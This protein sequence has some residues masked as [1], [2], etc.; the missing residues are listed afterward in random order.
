MSQEED[1]LIEPSAQGCDLGT[2][3]ANEELHLWP[4]E[5][6]AELADIPSPLKLPDTIDCS[7]L[8]PEAV[9]KHYWGYDEFRP[10][11]RDIVL[12]VLE[13]HDTLGLLPTGGG[14]SITFQVPGLMLPG[15]TLVVTPLISLM[16]D[17]V[18]HLRHRGIKAAAIHS[19]MHSNRISQTLDNCIYGRYKFLYVSPERLASSAF[20]AKLEALDISLL[21][22]DEC[23]CICQ[24][25]YDFR[26]SYLNILELRSLVPDVPIIALTATATPDVV[27]EVRRV[28]GFGCD[29]RTYQKSFFRPNLSYSIRYSPDKEQ[30]MLHILSRVAGSAIVYC[31]SRDLCRSIAK[32]LNE[33]GHSAT[34]FHAGLT[35]TERALR[36]SRW[37]RGEI[38]VMVATNA[39]GMGIDKPDVRLVLHLAMPTS[40]EEYFQEAG[41]AGRDGERAYAVAIVSQ[42]DENTLR[43][44]LADAFPERSYI[45]KVYDS[46][47]NYLGIGEGEGFQR[48]YDLEIDQFV[49]RFR[50]RPIQTRSAIE[51]MQIA[52]WLSYHEDDT[53]SRLMILYTREQLYQEHVGHDGLFRALLRLYTGLFSDY[54]Y[55][56]EADLAKQMGCGADDV[57]TML[58]A[59]S[60]Q[61]IIHYIPLKNIP[62]IVFHIRRED[63]QYLRIPRSAYEERRDR[64]Q[65][66]TDASLRYIS[67]RNTCRSRLLLSYFGEQSTQSCGMCDVCLRRESNGL[68]HY[69]IEDTER[70]MQQMFAEQSEGKPIRLHDLCH[71]LPY[72]PVDVALALRYLASETMKYRLAGELIYLR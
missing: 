47:C 55:I 35:H 61:N 52:G 2:N 29:S 14:K 28:L 37:M 20:K 53:R 60:R 45:L 48:S 41:R 54:V 69:I 30:M 15:L 19:G 18:D 49:R 23:H 31:R 21:V 25:G 3:E 51:I 71:N 22:V 67:S 68:H 59:L 13:G 27:A 39:F 42:T 16:K 5:W 9:L 1:M 11:Q 58:V 34:F 12:S 6:A 24:W 8:T 63:T 62:R 7:G 10:L 43:R 4:E 65:E 33:H 17:Q 46:L 44:R 66:R 56:S 32:F 64:M 50:M 36:Q 38:R 70:M 40:P 57:Y 26:P 72:I